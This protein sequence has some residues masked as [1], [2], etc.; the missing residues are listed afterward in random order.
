M[1]FAD[2]LGGFGV[3]AAA[4][5]TALLLSALW[6]S[7]RARRASFYYIRTAGRRIASR[8]LAA[9]F[10]LI[11]LA[12]LLISAR[13]YLL[14]GLPSPITDLLAHLQPTIAAPS[15]TPAPTTPATPSA[16]RRRATPTITPIPSDT[17]IPTPDLTPTPTGPYL[18]LFGVASHVN[19]KGQP[20]TLVERVNARNKRIHIFFLVQNARPGVIVQHTWYHNA[21]VI[22]SQQDVLM[23]ESTT[24]VSI[25]WQPT[26]GFEPGAYE[27]HLALD[28]RPQFIAKFEVR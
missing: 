3:I 6:R 18:T 13:W 14:H 12:G 19:A 7:I 23:H 22:F 2:L 26:G 9:S 20:I 15:P 4:V 1:S 16:T 28:G 5:S 8:R 25:S 21:K 27:V 11:I 17:P 24:P 10:L